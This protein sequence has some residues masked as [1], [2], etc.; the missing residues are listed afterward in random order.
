[1]IFAEPSPGFNG[2]PWLL[3]QEWGGSAMG[4]GC[5]E[6]L[7]PNT[8]V[9]GRRVSGRGQQIQNLIGLMELGI[10]TGYVV[11]VNALV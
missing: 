6:N 7:S 2:A 9:G 1:M 10:F 8:V 3:E 11:H 5:L 4:V